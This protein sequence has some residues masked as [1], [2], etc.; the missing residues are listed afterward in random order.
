[1]DIRISSV[2]ILAVDDV[3]LLSIQLQLTL[4]ETTFNAGQDVICLFLGIAVRHNIIGVPLKGYRRM[5]SS[6][7]LIECQVKKDIRQPRRSDAL[8]TKGNFRFERQVVAWR[9]RCVI[10][11][12]R[13]R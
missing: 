4:F 9:D 5:H 13:K 3:R 1:M 8:N 6:H 10:D 7:P 12:R 2:A 11:L